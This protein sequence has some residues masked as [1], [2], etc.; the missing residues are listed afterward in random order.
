MRLRQ[1]HYHTVITLS[2]MHTRGRSCV[3]GRLG[4]YALKYRRAVLDNKAWCRMES[5]GV[6]TKQSIICLA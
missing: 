5:S 6:I 3:W 4:L 2:V 1:V